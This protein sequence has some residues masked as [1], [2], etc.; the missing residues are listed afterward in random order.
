MR[1]IKSAQQLFPLVV[2]TSVQSPSNAAPTTVSYTP[3]A[4][5]GTYRLSAF[6]DVTTATTITFKTK[7]TY[8]DPAGSATTD[9]PGW[10]LENSGVVT[11][12]TANTAD[13]FT[14]IPYIFGI[15]NSGAAI[16]LADDAGTYTTCAYRLNTVLERLI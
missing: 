2:K 7:L 14:T 10:Y 3:P 1:I 6:L 4:T 15:D 5:A 11:Q 16:S 12:P 13:R 9:R 8:T